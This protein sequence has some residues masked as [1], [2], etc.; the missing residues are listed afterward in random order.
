MNLN[1]STPLRIWCG[2]KWP[3]LTEAQVENFCGQCEL[4][5]I[6]GFGEMP[7]S[8]KTA[9]QCMINAMRKPSTVLRTIR[10]NYEKAIA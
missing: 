6:T 5:V 8:A 1:I 3:E 7:D 2:E 10:I 4:L 9:V